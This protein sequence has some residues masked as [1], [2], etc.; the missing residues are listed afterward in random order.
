MD[1]V[2]FNFIDLFAGIGGFRLAFESTSGKCVFASE[3][4]KFSQ[5]T[6]EANFAHKPE[7]DITKINAQDI[8]DHDILTAGF[9]CQPFSIA[10]VSKN[11][12]LGNSHGFDHPTQG[13]LFFDLVRII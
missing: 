2:C 11:N 4:D 3:W 1:K 9:P 10:G 6:Y 12:A 8:P 5:Q 13:T 7:G